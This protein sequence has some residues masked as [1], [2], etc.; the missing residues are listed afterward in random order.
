MPPERY[1]RR[2]FEIAQR[3]AGKVSPNPLV[4]C[5]IVHQDRIIGEGYHQQ[6]G[7]A[8]AEVNAIRSIQ[9]A[10]LPLLKASTLY[11]SLEPCFHYGNTPPC[12]DLV[13]EHKIPKVV[14]ASLDPNPKVAGQ[15]VQKLS[16]SGVEVITGFLEDENR[17]LAK[18]FLHA[19]Q[20]NR[21]YVY[22]KWAES[23]HGFIGHPDEQIWLSNPLSKRLS[24]QMRAE[25]DAILVGPQTLI[26]DQADL[27]NRLWTGGHPVRVT[28]DLR[29]DLPFDGPFFNGK[30]RTIV[31]GH[32]ERNYPT[33]VE[34]QDLPSGNLE[35]VLPFMLD[36]LWQTFRLQSV[37]IEGGAR[38][39]Q[40]FIDQQLWQEAWIYH[41]PHPLSEGI[42]APKIVGTIKQQYQLKSDQITILNA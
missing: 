20:Y 13:L 19:F 11:V 25:I 26:T 4:G 12:V 35:K 21:P 38:T 15:S 23:Q 2:C 42:Q 5:V 32:S 40:A 9:S 39:L 17:E 30:T 1:M 14:I 31:F 3:S 37:L 10:D 6:Y 33:T 29:G 28:Y 18:V 16:A 41:T 36:Q 7:Q 34:F 27:T 24:H 8:H 22:L